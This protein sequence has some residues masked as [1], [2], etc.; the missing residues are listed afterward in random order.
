MDLLEEIPS[1]LATIW[2]LF[3]EEEF[4]SAVSKYNNASTSKL[5]KLS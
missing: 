5:D 1:K 3:S 4:R 2:K